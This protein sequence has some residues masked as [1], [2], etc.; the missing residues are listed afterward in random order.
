[1][2]FLEKQVDKNLE[3]GGLTEGTNQCWY[4]M[5]CNIVS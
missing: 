5:A 2:L 3:T 4:I 1:M